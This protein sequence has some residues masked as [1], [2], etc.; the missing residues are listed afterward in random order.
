MINREEYRIT[1]E[2]N[3]ETDVPTYTI[4]KTDL[5]ADHPRYEGLPNH[6]R[7]IAEKTKFQYPEATK[8]ILDLRFKSEED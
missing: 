2:F 6:L 8:F 1:V 5:P 3:L 4:I 7:D